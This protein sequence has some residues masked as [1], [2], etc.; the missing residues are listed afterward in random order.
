MVMM[1]V[2]KLTDPDESPMAF[3]MFLLCRTSRPLIISV[4]RA[5]SETQIVKYGI[6][7]GNGY[8]S[9]LTPL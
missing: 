8:P 7:K 1:A 9:D 4:R 6:S 5:L 3:R 2:Y